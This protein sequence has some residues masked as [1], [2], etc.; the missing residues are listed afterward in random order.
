MQLAGQPVALLGDRQRGIAL[1]GGYGG[2]IYQY[3]DATREFRVS[4]THRMAP[5]HF[6]AVRAAPIRLGEGA[7]GMKASLTWA[8]S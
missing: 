2:V 6:E 8:A 4:A 7:V 5:E 1:A 3:D